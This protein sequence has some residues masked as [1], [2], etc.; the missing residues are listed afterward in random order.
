[1][2]LGM[3][4]QAEV[5]IYIR[6]GPIYCSIVVGDFNTTANLNDSLFVKYIEPHVGPVLD[7][8]PSL[9]CNIIP[10]LTTRIGI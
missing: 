7:Y 4:V 10:L 2:L 8:R 1:M 3:I 6:E 9:F 5:T